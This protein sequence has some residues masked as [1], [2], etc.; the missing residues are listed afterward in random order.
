MSARDLF[1]GHFNRTTRVSRYRNVSI[2]DFN[3]AE[4][5]VVVVATAAIKPAVLQSDQQTN[6]WL[7]TGQMPFLSPNQQCQSSEGKEFNL[8]I[9]LK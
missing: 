7:F 4:M 1:N 5:V 3:G 9:G 8:S 2:L 6:I